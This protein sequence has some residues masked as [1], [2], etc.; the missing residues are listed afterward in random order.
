MPEQP[1]SNGK[2]LIAAQGWSQDLPQLMELLRLVNDME[3]PTC[4]NADILFCPRRDAI[5]RECTYVD[6]LRIKFKEVSTF[7]GSRTMAGWPFGPNGLAMDVMRH[8][9]Q[10]WQAGT[11]KYDAVLLMEADCVP[12]R[13]TWIAELLTEW[14]SQDKLALG[15]WDGASGDYAPASHMN[16]NLIFHPR[17]IDRV[18]DMA[19]GDVPQWGWDMAF[20]KQFQPY[21]TPSKLIYSDYQLNTPKNPLISEDQLFGPK[22]HIHPENPLRNIDQYPCWLH[23]CKGLKAINWV[24]SR[25]CL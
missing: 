9:H 7:R 21:S 16:G 14:H 1:E 10:Q 22:R 5:L 13:R 15:H 25:F 12:L 4:D 23:G 11:F 6:R 8:V 17:L 24:R 20:W 2:L 18:P 19:Y 3:G